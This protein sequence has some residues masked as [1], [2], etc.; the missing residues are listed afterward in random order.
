MTTRS[1]CVLVLCLLS[2]SSACAQSAL[3][4]G[5]GFIDVPGGPVW[6]RIVSSGG[7]GDSG[8][9]T[10]VLFVHGGPGGSSCVFSDLAAALGQDRPVV[11]YDQLGSGRSGRPRDASLWHLDR[12]VRELAAVRKALGL[13][14]VHLVGHSWGA[15]LATE[16]VVKSRPGGVASLVLAGPLLST[17]RWID[18]ANRLRAQLPEAVQRTLTLHER[19][20][21]TASK[22]YLAATEVFY[23]KFLFHRQPR[24]EMP[25]CRSWEDNEVV[26]EQMWGPSEFHATGNLL[27][28][29]VTPQLAGLNLPVLFIVGRYDE[30]RPETVAGFQASVHGAKMEVLEQSGHMAPVE[31]PVRYR[32]ILREFFRSVDA[33]SSTR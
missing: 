25:E 16:Y 7:S 8:E 32:E 2:L 17:E 28:F 20:G 21:T 9:A 23:D 12:F 1:Q 4:L 29:D 30:A 24:P 18:D 5:E 11:L 13:R 3:R 6:Y 19:A 14:R 10:P 26:Y 31:E 22:E 15:A 33:G 27:H